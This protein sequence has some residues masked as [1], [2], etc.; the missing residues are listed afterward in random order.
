VSLANLVEGRLRFIH[1]LT[2]PLLAFCLMVGF[3]LSPC[4]AVAP[5]SVV[6]SPKL[7]S[8]SAIAISPSG[9]IL[10]SS[11][12]TGVPDSQSG[13][14]YYQIRLWDL[15]TG[16]LLKSLCGH[17]GRITEV[18]FSSDGRTLASSSEDRTVK[19]WDVASGQELRTLVGP[20]TGVFSVAFS[21]DGRK[22]V[23][24][25][26]DNISLWDAASGT[27]LA[28][29]VC[30]QAASDTEKFSA[31]SVAFSPDNH[32]FACGAQDAT[33]RIFDEQL[34]QTA[35]FQ[36][37]YEIE[38]TTYS[39]DGKELASGSEVGE[40]L[41]Y[42][43]A[44]HHLVRK[45]ESASRV[46]GL[47]FSRDGKTLAASGLDR[48]LE[49]W[50]PQTG[51]RLKKL[52]GHTDDVHT[53]AFTPDGK[54]LVSGSDDGTIK[55]WDVAS[56]KLV[57]NILSVAPPAGSSGVILAH[58]G[59]QTSPVYCVVFSPDGRLIASA[60][61][62]NPHT[63]N[64]APGSSVVKIWDATTKRELRTLDLQ[65]DKVT[66]VAFSRDG[67]KIAAA[68][69]DNVVKV[70]DVSAG[71]LLLQVSP[72]FGAGVKAVAFSADGND[73]LIGGYGNPVSLW[74]LAS[75]QKV[76]DISNQGEWFNGGLSHDGL[77][78]ADDEDQNVRVWSVGSSKNLMMSL[79]CDNPDSSNPAKSLAFS[80]SDKL[81]AVGNENGTAIV[82]DVASGW[83]LHELIG[84]SDSILSIA[85]N[86]SGTMLAC[87]SQDKRI[88]LWDVASGKMSRVLA[89]L[90]GQP[91]S[92]AFS[93]DGKTLA[94]GSDD[95]T[96]ELWP[97]S[98]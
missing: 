91:K 53:V 59:E 72:H 14:C 12:I 13:S 51:R 41:I 66:T 9:Q 81:I 94:S 20:S 2:V 65:K 29:K 43:V 28:S 89:V 42:N 16:K 71:K 5:K 15:H 38:V 37:N 33:T 7:T 18:A 73:L 6:H 36:N 93:P 27:L 19:L 75:G 45:M 80:P 32:S 76:S 88:S 61:G 21:P 31:F 70:W 24:A 79:R 8:I 46:Y 69:F 57:R 95:G 92:I 62:G 58:G 49:L 86:P 17:S 4:E 77:M 34:H 54:T 25:A 11:C 74:N 44:S 82:F 90:S 67:H 39:P 30:K 64:A 56:G 96:V 83:R 22:V 47:A 26:G 68:A 35:L 55:P 48:T 10:A 40:I 84:S 23:S 60:A 3:C 52:V 50:D 97:V 85:F 63:G 98:P 1:L 78:L 87:G